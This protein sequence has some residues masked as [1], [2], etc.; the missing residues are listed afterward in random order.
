[1]ANQAVVLKKQGFVYLGLLVFFV[2]SLFCGG[3]VT[4][5]NSS[6]NKGA[7]ANKDLVRKKASVTKVK[8]GKTKSGKA[9]KSKAAK[10]IKL[11]LEDFTKS[12]KRVWDFQDP[13]NKQMPKFWEPVSGQWEI[14]FEPEHPGNKVLRQKLV[15]RNFQ[16]LVSRNKLVNF[17]FSA[18]LRADSFEQKTRNW[19][20]GLIFRQEKA[21]YY[22]KYRIT[23]ANVALL[24]CTPEIV[25]VLPSSQGSTT[26]A[27]ATGRTGKKNEQM[28]MILPLTNTTD[29]WHTLSVACYG[30]RITL[31]LNGRE[32]RMLTDSIIGSGKVGVYTYKTQ[33]FVDDIRL[34]YLPVPEMK[35]SIFLNRKQF[36]RKQDREL[37]IYYKTP[38]SGPVELKVLDPKGKMFTNLSQG[39]HSAGF[40]SVPW[41][42]QGVDGQLP[43]AGTYTIELKAAGK[44]HKAKIP[45]KP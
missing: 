35:G 45:I 23:A 17:E 10:K 32:I 1:M 44:K 20:M 18:K 38:H 16:Y 4:P 6:E 3:M 24:R 25:N 28:L 42:G 7:A 41:S 30:D 5:A 14:T 2:F 15:K 12:I 37:L 22:Y 31:K 39:L 29:Q 40:H 8:T 19:Q 43:R 26:V 9:K 27:S 13:R 11:E 34:F 21:D 33:A 36:R